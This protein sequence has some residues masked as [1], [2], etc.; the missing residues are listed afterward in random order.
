[1][2]SPRNK[3]RIGA[4]AGEFDQFAAELE[5]ATRG[6]LEVNVEVLEQMEKKISLQALHA[7][8]SLER[9]GPSLVT[10]L[11]DDLDLLPSTASRLSDRLAEAGWITRA[12]SPVNRRATVLEL[13]S[14]GRSVLRELLTL[15]K[16]ALKS[17]VGQ[18]DDEDRAA[19][20]QGTRAFTAARAK[21][22]E[23]S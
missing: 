20:L 6:F 23:P 19:L 13:T 22:S 7:L 8:Q 5:L 9:L 1:M 10:E 12:V 21:F 2:A 14:S 18:M 4:A 17:V 11:G 16:N 3:N 15:R